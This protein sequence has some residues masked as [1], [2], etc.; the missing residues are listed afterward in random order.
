MNQLREPQ[1]A[2]VLLLDPRQRLLLM[3][4][5]LPSAP[6]S[7]GEWF[8]VGGGLEPGETVRDAALREVAEETGFGD[9]VL[10][11]VVWQRR[12]RL[13]LNP[14][15]VLLIREHFLI[16]H[17]AGGEPRRDGWLP[18][19]QALIDDIR[20]WTY[21]EIAAAAEPIHPVGLA[22]LLPDVLAG[23]YPVP[24]LEIAWR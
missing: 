6:E 1:A 3:K 9:A 5:R 15:E 10:G 19:E 11:P 16:A 20:W 23:R 22:D 8:T 7:P 13:A 18:H 24:P 17:C 2:R 14:G 12:G 21:A 4:G